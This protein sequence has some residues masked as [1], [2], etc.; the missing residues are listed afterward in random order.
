MSKFTKI[1][2]VCGKTFETNIPHQKYCS[3]DCR[4]DKNLQK[5]CAFCGKKFLPTYS[6]NKYCSVECR[7]NAAKYVHTVEVKTCAYCGEEFKPATN[8]VKY[9][10]VECQR[11]ANDKKKHEEY[12]SP[13]AK[14][15][16][17]F[18]DKRIEEAN[19]C[20]LSYGYYIALRR[21][22]KTFE[23][24]KATYGRRIADD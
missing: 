10:S 7:R 14:P 11:K 9:C 21:L 1:C 15:K 24:L 16:E 23:E 4:L 5:E 3:Y 13:F 17:S 18:L 19:A 22:G 12:A 6:F 20:G 8:F 2:P